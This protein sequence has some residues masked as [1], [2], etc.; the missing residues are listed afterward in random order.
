MKI[1]ILL[2]Y[3]ENYTKSIAGAASIM[4]SDFIKYSIYKKGT[5]VFGNL[6]PDRTSLTKNFV[7]I[8]IKTKLFS[9]T[10]EYTNSFFKKI[11]NNPPDIIEIH[12]RPESIHILAKM[13]I[14]SKLILFFHN[15]PLELAGSKTFLERNN[16]I[17]SCYKI[18]FVS[19]WVKNQFFKNLSIKDKN[20]C[21]II[22]PGHKLVNT[23]PKKEKII[24][25]SGKLNKSKGFDLFSESIIPILNKYNDWKAIVV[26][27]EPR[28]NI[29]INHQNV[30]FVGWLSFANTFKY[31]KK[32]SI[33]IVPSKWEEPFGRTAM[34]TAACGC[35]T[36]ISDRGGLKETFNVQKELIIKNLNSKYLI[37]LISKCINKK[38]YLRKIQLENFKN[39]IHNI[40]DKV[41]QLDKIRSRSK[42][43]IN[44]FSY[45]PPKVL[46]VG[47]FNEKN[48]HRLFN[49]SISNKITSGL[50]RN[51]LDVLNFDYRNYQGILKSVDDKIIDIINHYKPGLVL[52]GHNNIM[53]RSSLEFI[54]KKKIRTALW[55]EDALNNKGPDYRNSLNL[56]EKNNDLIDNY[57]V[58]TCPTVIKTIIP[59]IKLSFIPI[60][61]DKNIENLKIYKYKNKYKDLFFAMSHGVNYGKLKKNIFD[62]R[63]DFINKLTKLNPDLSC[64]F[65]GIN[66]EEPKWG[67]DFYNSISK[68]KMA[69]NLSRGQSV[70]YY[71]SN[72]VASYMGNGIATIIDEGTKYRDFFND[73][74]VIFYKNLKD[75]S[76]I[77][78]TLKNNESKIY[79]IGMKGKNRYHKIFNN[80]LVSNFIFNK[81][82]NRKIDKKIIWDK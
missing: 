58:T 74:E 51:D 19:R 45:K 28:E 6:H 30:K 4:V 24:I 35:L 66:K 21:E 32:S 23:F 22:Y 40:K 75:L 20:N 48:S 26:G 68:C 1:A 49:I 47:N 80:Y 8:P 10:L 36:I 7:N 71:S 25:F 76:N 57:F 18:I 61:V 3:K 17:K 42:Y 62:D 59:K 65:L 5:T 70:K 78:N 29:R 69:L 27:S 12:N 52:F 2:P 79:K 81:V 55:F 9:K 39:Q 15:D 13:R 31:Y 16:L 43:V 50:I 46:H 38:D 53:S 34:E 60:P 63:E 33:A 54:K 73:D 82:F 67:I 72:R 14:S 37:K 77:L 56:V 41:S 11:K 44:Y 64:E